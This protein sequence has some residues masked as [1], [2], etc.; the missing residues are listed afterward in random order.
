MMNDDDRRCF[1]SSF[2]QPDPMFIM[3][4]DL[5]QLLSLAKQDDKDA[6]RRELNVKG[7]EINSQDSDGRS[8]LHSAAEEG[9][10]TAVS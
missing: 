3:S 9:S 6:F 1:P 8:L 7:L 10:Q 4:K 2:R 5:L